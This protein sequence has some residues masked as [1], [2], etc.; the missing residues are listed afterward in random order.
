MIFVKIQNYNFKI[1]FSNEKFE[2]KIN[3]IL[4]INRKIINNFAK[5]LKNRW[6]SI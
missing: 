4:A 3:L 2:F 1:V 5:N 6:N